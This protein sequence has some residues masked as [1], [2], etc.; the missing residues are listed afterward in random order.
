M[1][2]IIKKG[3]WVEIKLNLLSPEE[4]DFHVPEDTKKVPLILK[5]KGFLKEDALIGDEVKINTIIDREIVGELIAAN[6]G[7]NH[8]FGKPVEE[9]IR[10]V[11]RLRKTI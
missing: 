3:S 7:Y 9:L 4:R 1:K 5:T 11:K 8:G 6:P 10:L 2:E